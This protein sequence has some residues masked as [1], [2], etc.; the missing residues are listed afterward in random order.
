M[1]LSALLRER[2]APQWERIFSHPF[3]LGIGEGDV[4]LD[5]FKFYVKQDYVFLIEYCRV[6]ALAAAKAPD[7]ETMTAFADLL[8]TTVHTEMALHRSY[9]QS[10]GIKPQELEAT[11]AA[12]TTAAY[13][14]YLLSVAYAGSTGE[15]LGALLPCLWGYCA[16]G[17]R[18][19]ARGLPSERLFAQWIQTYASEEYAA[20]AERMLSLFDRLAEGAGSRE[21]A[22]MEQHFRR[23]TQYEYLFWEMA[24]KGEAWPLAEGP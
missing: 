24:H 23:T 16:I 3:V 6:V 12:P 21:R 1:G 11:V 18:L 15:V 4:P 9:C 7:L 5:R 8:H 10:F 13:T 22:R 20:F 17:E 19:A 14:S 2:T